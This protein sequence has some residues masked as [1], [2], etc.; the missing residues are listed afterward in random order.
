MATTCESRDLTASA[1]T[2]MILWGVPIAAIATAGVL[3]HPSSTFTVAAALFW[4]GAACALNAY[5]C[6]RLHCYITGP[7]FILSGLLVLLAGFDVISV[8]GTW[9]MVGV[10]AGTCLAYK[11]ESLFGTKY[12]RR[13]EVE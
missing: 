9:V 12:V 2:F 11:I 4:A 3:S 13:T 1:R 10:V 5:R 7:L 6:R 8:Q